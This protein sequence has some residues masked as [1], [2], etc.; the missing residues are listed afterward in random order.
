MTEHARLHRFDKRVEDLFE[1]L[2]RRITTAPHL[3]SRIKSVKTVAS[4]LDEIFA[5]KMLLSAWSVSLRNPDD[6]QKELRRAIKQALIA[7]QHHARGSSKSISNLA[8][9]VLFCNFELHESYESLSPM[10]LSTSSDRQVQLTVSGDVLQTTPLARQLMAGNADPR[11]LLE[12]IG[13]TAAKASGA[14]DVAHSSQL[15]TDFADRLDTH[16]NRAEFW[17]GLYS[18]LALAYRA[19]QEHTGA[20][21]DSNLCI[22]PNS[23]FVQNYSGEGFNR[24]IGLN[25]DDLRKTLCFTRTSRTDDVDLVT[26][27]LLEVKNGFIT[28]GRLLFDSIAP[29]ALQWLQENNAWKDV[30]S[31]PFEDKV[32]VLLENVGFVTGPVNE[33]GQWQT[34]SSTTYLHNLLDKNKQNCPGEIDNVAFDGTNLILM[35]CKSIYPFSNYRN[36]AGR[37]SDEDI[38]G[39]VQNALKKQ[40]WLQE[41][42]G[43]PVALSAIVIEV[44]QYIDS[45]NYQ[46]DVPV[47]DFATFEYLIKEKTRLMLT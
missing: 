39:W 28:S 46:Q 9:L 33:Y 1:E 27:P 11:T 13:F 7:V 6:L 23:V 2:E 21:T 45:E 3:N 43:I 19:L 37:V 31:Q 17:T 22:L 26:H 36:L 32:K 20:D 10:W 47:L 25:A 14:L 8:D 4:T 29:Y 18:R 34:Q 42:T 30:I 35:E 15:V 16:A 12:S 24:F 41:S 38:D 40:K 5:K 44:A